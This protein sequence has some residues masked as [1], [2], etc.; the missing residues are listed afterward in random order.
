MYSVFVSG[1][2]SAPSRRTG[3]D[4]ILDQRRIGANGMQVLQTSMLVGKQWASALVWKQWAS[5]LV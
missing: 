2:M 1:L 5:V 4:P 3:M